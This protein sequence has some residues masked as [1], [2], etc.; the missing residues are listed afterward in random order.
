MKLAK[1]PPWLVQLFD[2][3]QPDV[4]G[5]RKQMFGYPC[6]FANGHLFTGL[7][8]DTLFVRLGEADRA[9]LLASRGARSFSPMEGRPMK[10]YVVLPGTM[11][12]DEEAV[13]RWMRRGLGFA[14]SL[15]PKVKAGGAPAGK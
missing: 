7:F 5:E 3:L 10:E 14:E 15:P 1:S 9:T 13:K 12:E 4:G 6:A 11:L 8:Q 2:A